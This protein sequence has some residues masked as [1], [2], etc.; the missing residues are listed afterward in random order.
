MTL[1]KNYNQLHAASLIETI[2]A[3][4]ICAACLAIAIL[5][6]VQ[7]S[8]QSQAVLH[9]QAE[10]QLAT[11]IYEDW[12]T[13]TIPENDQESFKGYTITTDKQKANVDSKWSTITYKAT[14]QNT[15][16][17]KKIIVAEDNE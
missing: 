16:I 11:A 8:S 10:Q 5:V 1:S 2:V 13:D 6:F 3:L 4:T 14:Y 15:K 12:I 7:V 17:E 9:I